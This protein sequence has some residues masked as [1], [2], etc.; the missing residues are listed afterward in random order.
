MAKRS[1]LSVV[2]V[3][4]VIGAVSVLSK[5]GNRDKLFG[6]LNSAKLKKAFSMENQSIITNSMSSATN[7]TLRDVAE[8]P[9]GTSTLTIDENAMVYEGGA[10]TTIFQY[11]EEQAKAAKYH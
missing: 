8:A 3:S 10:Q 4:L 2:L 9:A 6:M 1:G 11:N 7:N 5:K